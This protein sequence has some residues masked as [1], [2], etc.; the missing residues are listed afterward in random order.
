LKKYEAI[1]ILDDQRL[2]DAGT[3]FLKQAEAFVVAQGGT[4][5]QTTQMG[6]RQMAHPIR[7]RRTGVYWSLIFTIA[8][9]KIQVIKDHY[10]LEEAILRLVI[11]IDD[12][13]ERIS[14]KPTEAEGEAI[15]AARA[16]AKA[17]AKV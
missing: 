13:P 15:A 16:E 5:V 14:L 8:E 1:F 9:D 10:K 6:Q 2:D 12:R 17:E 3:T 7:R 11:F 4:V